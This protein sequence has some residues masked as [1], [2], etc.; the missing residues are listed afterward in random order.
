MPSWKQ[1]KENWFID[2]F[3]LALPQLTAFTPEQSVLLIE[4]R[5]TGE[6]NIDPP[7]VQVGEAHQAACLLVK[8]GT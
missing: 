5:D 6:H 1:L 4:N 3:G 8:P 2:K 7:S